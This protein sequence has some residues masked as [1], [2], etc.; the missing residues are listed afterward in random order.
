MGGEFCCYTLLH[1]SYLRFFDAKNCCYFGQ[2]FCYIVVKVNW[3]FLTSKNVHCQDSFWLLFGFSQVL[4]CRKG[5]DI[6]GKGRAKGR[7]GRGTKLHKIAEH[8]S[9]FKVCRAGSKSTFSHKNIKIFSDTSATSD[10]L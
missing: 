9:N 6:T 4:D 7:G 3:N 1:L 2:N 10:T 5:W 8:N